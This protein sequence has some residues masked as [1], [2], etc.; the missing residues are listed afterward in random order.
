MASAS[1]GLTGAILL[2]TLPSDVFDAVIPVLVLLACGLMIAPA[3]A[4]GVGGRTAGRKAPVTSGPAPMAIAFLA[5]IYGGYFGAAQGV[6]L[7]AMLAVFVP[8]DLKRSNALKNVLAG[9]VNGVAAVLFIVFADVAWEAVGPG[10]RRLGRSAARSGRRSAAA[11]RPSSC[12][13]SSSS[14]AWSWP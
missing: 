4:V 13:P 5:G 11:S 10:R 1:G 3:P 6:I 14:S 2:L 12:A 9:T 8:D 7:L